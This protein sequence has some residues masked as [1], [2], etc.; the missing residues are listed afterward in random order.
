MKTRKVSVAAG[1]AAVAATI[2]FSGAPI[3][4]AATVQPFGTRETVGDPGGMMVTAYTVNALAPS[5]DAIP[6]RVMGR[7][8]EATVTVEAVRGST[9]PVIPPFMARTPG[10]RNY[11]V[12]AGVATPQGLSPMS[13]A[14]GQR[15]TGKLYFDVVGDVPNS[16]AY[17]DGMMDLMLWVG[18]P[19]GAP[20]PAAPMP[21]MPPP[22]AAPMPAAPPPPP[23]PM[24]MMPAAPPAMGPGPMLS[25]AG[26]PM[27]PDGSE[28]P[29]Y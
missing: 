24:P 3:G 12:L 6:Y 18:N 27:L 11:P 9:T 23:A 7:L 17:N 2:A 28:M 14:Q 1:A 15:N 25:P 10:G 20:P 29:G 8:Y 13:L 16:V 21:M 19:V 5:S 26:N 22:P 4:S